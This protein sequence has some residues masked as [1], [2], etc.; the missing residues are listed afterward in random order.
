MPEG[1]VSIGRVLGAWGIQGDIKIAPLAD[2]ELFQPGLGI[3][4]AGKPVTI[5][6]VNASGQ[7]LRVKVSGIDDRS[8]AAD[9]RGQH[10]LVAEADLGPAGEGRYYRFELIGLAVVTTAGDPIGEITDV[11]STG[12]NDVF[13]A[14][15]PRGD[16]LI[17]AIDDVVTSIDLGTRSVTIDPIPGLLPE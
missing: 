15:G 5:E 17:P 1:Y 6:R 11:F 12:S 3:N 9:L 14:H 2:I 16:I 10:L 13:V 7:H 8:E 4:L